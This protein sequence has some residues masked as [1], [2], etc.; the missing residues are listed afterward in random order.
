MT[1]FL[2][3]YE[4]PLVV[5]DKPANRLLYLSETVRLTEY[6]RE[7]ESLVRS[8]ILKFMMDHKLILVTET[9]STK[10]S[11]DNTASIHWLIH[12]HDFRNIIAQREYDDMLMTL[13]S[14]NA[15][16]IIDLIN[17]HARLGMQVDAIL[18]NTI[19][20]RLM[21]SIQIIPY[22]VADTDI[23]RSWND[24]YKE[25]PW[26]WILIMIQSILKSDTKA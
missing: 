1:K 22:Q 13:E 19:I 25:I 24:I 17:L 5:E 21:R 9:D 16:F 2:Y 12:F 3:L 26:I 4:D 11:G 14:S 7:D 20:T 18:L 23:E 10:N 15:E 6:E 8:L